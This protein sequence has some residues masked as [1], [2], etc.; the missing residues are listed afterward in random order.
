MNKSFF[1]AMACAA[2]LISSNLSA[3]EPT[4]SAD[5]LTYCLLPGKV[6]NLGARMVYVSPRK[7]VLSTRVECDIR[8]GEV[9]ANRDNKTTQSIGS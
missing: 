1:L 8:G 3:S 2:L 7:P 9:L 5:E 4:P 6:R